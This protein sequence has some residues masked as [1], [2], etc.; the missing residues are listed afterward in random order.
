MKPSLIAVTV[1]AAFVMSAC[2][3]QEAA[4]TAPA[5][6]ETSA[7][8]EAAAPEESTAPA[9]AATP[10]AL[11]PAADATALVLAKPEIEG[12]TFLTE[13]SGGFAFSSASNCAYAAAASTDPGRIGVIT[14][15]TDREAT[16]F[17]MQ[18]M[19]VQTPGSTLA[20]SS[21]ISEIAMADGTKMLQREYSL[22]ASNVTTKMNI[23]ARVDVESNS[24]IV[25]TGTC[26][27]EN[28][29]QQ[30]EFNK[31]V[32]GLSLSAGAPGEF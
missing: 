6:A 15:T 24:A 7:A 11:A 2:S 16:E 30:D 13:E 20:I 19:P 12:F 1:C 21:D 18:N 3:S 8:A 17:L 5:P 26:V 27:L 22:T 25:A 9:E 29:A 14:G 28:P 32:S 10:Q 23:A 4:P 31:F